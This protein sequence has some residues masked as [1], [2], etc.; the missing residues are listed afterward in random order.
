M[1]S[2]IEIPDV[3]RQACRRD[4]VCSLKNNTSLSVKTGALDAA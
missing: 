1:N 2:S 3:D 4:Q